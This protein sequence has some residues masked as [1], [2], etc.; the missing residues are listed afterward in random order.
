MFSSVYFVQMASAT[1]IVKVIVEKYICVKLRLLSTL[2]TVFSKALHL[3]PL[4]LQRML[5][6]F[7]SLL[8]CLSV[9]YL[10]TQ[11]VFDQFG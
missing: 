6:F 1:V 3:S 10:A 11:I 5:S 7:Q 9:C 4:P 2:Q 8:F